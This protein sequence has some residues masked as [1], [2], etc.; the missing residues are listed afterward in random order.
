MIENN[1]YQGEERRKVDDHKHYRH[2]SR[3]DRLEG[4]V[5]G[6]ATNQAAT[7]TQ[8]SNLAKNVDKLATGF[9][10]FTTEQRTNNKTN[11]SVILSAGTLLLALVVALGQGFVRSPLQ[12]LQHDVAAEKAQTRIIRVGIKD[13]LTLLTKGVAADHARMG[14]QLKHHDEHIERYRQEINGLHKQIG[15][16]H[17]SDRE[18][19]TELESRLAHLERLIFPNAK[20]RAGK[21]D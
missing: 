8:L 4:V 5:E 7:E 9:D 12:D 11:W 14:E 10:N 1:E 17:L 19:H 3:L 6:L 2:E 15:S 21:P 18:K 16:N 20:Y 13:D